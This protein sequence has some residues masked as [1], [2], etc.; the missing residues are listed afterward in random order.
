MY[1]NVDIQNGLNM[2]SLTQCFIVA[3]V[4]DMLG[5]YLFILPVVLENL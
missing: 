1:V 2:I 4:S 5:L 3:I